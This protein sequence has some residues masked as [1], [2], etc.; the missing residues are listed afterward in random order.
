VILGLVD[1]AVAAG[2]RQHKAC[3]TLGVDCRTMQR[4]RGQ[5]VGE[6]GRAGP[7]TAP[8]NKLTES[9]RRKIIEIVN[10]PEYR[11]LSIKQI[12]PIL[13]DEGV[14]VASESTMYR[15][16]REAGQAAHRGAARP[17]RHHPR[18]REA[19]ATGPNQ[20]W[21]WDITYLPSP[22]RGSFFY[23][24]MIIDVFSRKIVGRSVHEIECA[25][26]AAELI[27]AACAAEGLDHEPLILHS[28]NGGPM[29]GATMLATMQELGIVPSFSRPRV[30]NDNPYSESLFRTA[31]YRPEYPSGPFQSLEAAREWVEWFVDWYNHRH[32]H[33]AIRFVTPAQ[34]HAGQDVD[35]LA[36]RRQLYEQVRARS[37]QRWAKNTRDWSRVEVV[38]LNPD[39]SHATTEVA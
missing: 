19:V 21:S 36:R 11:D 10:R 29:K 31:K 1:E 26:L 33:S 35:I 6:D 7:T 32:R 9:E 34:R 20:V 5:D 8:Q 27:R 25:V 3:E 14:Y 39:S 12:V 22:V 16:L 13:A 38:R 18:P 30:S 24:Y 17:P 28:D 15:V 2:T 23:L 4:W 37:P